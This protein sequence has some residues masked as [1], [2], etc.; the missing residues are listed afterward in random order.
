MTGP[1]LEIDLDKISA[2][3][4]IL[5]GRLAARGIAV[6]GV[7]KAG[8][9]S[10]EIAKALLEAGVSGLGDS[11]IENIER[12]RGG[13][14]PRPVLS[15]IRT[16]MP[17]QVDRIVRH[18]DISF[19]TDLDV[20][21]QLSSAA[22]AAGRIHGVVLMVELGDLREGIMPGDLERIFRE[23]LN[24][25]NIALRGIGANL[26][27]LSG[28]SPDAGNM[29]ALS[30]I[31][32]S[33]E[34]AFG[35]ALDI[36]SGGNSANINWALGDTDIGRIN[37]LRLGEAILLGREALERR[38]IDGL[39]T[40][41]FALVAEVIESGIKP[42]RPWGTIAQNA[43][44]ETVQTAD[45]GKIMQAILALGRQDSDPAGLI[46]PSGMT[47]LGSSSDHLVLDTGGEPLSAGAELRFGVNYTTLLRA[48]TSPFVAKTMMKARSQQGAL[49][50]A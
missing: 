49:A 10:P 23:V 27:C 48:M 50:A 41:A 11:R 36:V 29:A 32:V 8:L 19:N 46:P 22:Q 1:R 25:P 47:I 3:A 26:A 20:V 30:A 17:S 21:R 40:D 16:P 9:G 38:A 15:L 44:G 45:S 18:A 31:A 2:N 13:I 12:L 39:H 6:T 37:D 28:T 35:V 33:M 5:V 43:F 7:T 4:R 42:S 14:G 24:L 34:A